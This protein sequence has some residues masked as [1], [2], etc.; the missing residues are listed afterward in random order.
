[1][2]SD[3]NFEP[4]LYD[5]AGK[6]FVLSDKEKERMKLVLGKTIGSKTGKDYIAEKLSIEYME[7][8]E[9]L[10]KEMDSP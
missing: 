3:S 6:L 9:N 4:L 10:I 8:A 7:I 2:S 5:K 1:L